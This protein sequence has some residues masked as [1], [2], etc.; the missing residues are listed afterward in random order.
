MTQGRDG[1]TLAP[2][3]A[4]RLI[5]VARRLSVVAAVFTIAVLVA[6]TASTSHAAGINDTISVTNNGALFSGSLETFPAGSGA[7]GHLSPQFFVKGK[8]TLLGASGGPTLDSVGS[9]DHHIA[10]AVPLDFFGLSAAAFGA[11]VGCGPF[12]LPATGPLFGT[13]FV[14][15]FSPTATGN[16]APENAICSPDFAIGADGAGLAPGFPNTTGVFL[17]QGVA[18]ESP[19]DGITPPGH[20][21]LAVANLFPVVLGPDSPLAACAPVPPSTTPGTSLGTITE[22][23]TTTLAPGLNNVPPLNNSPVSALNPFPAG[24]IPPVNP[25]FGV[26]YTQNATIGGCLSLLAGPIGLAFDQFGFLFV[27]N[28]AG[29]LSPALAAAPRFLTVYAPG[30]FGDAFPKAAIGVPGTDTAG[31]FKQPISVAVMTGT[32][33]LTCDGAPGTPGCFPDDVIFVTDVADN[34]IKI[35]APFTDF[36]FSTFFFQGTLLGTIHGGATKLK[37]PEGIALSADGDTLYVANNAVDSVSEFTDITSDETGG[38]IAPTLI[39]QSRHSKLNLPVGVALAG[40]TPTPTPAPSISV[41]GA[42]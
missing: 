36:S 10:V 15:I 2:R 33:P 18:Y 13:G 35:Y 29:R 12:G 19:F 31:A 3:G 41:L 23:D 28:N 37:A 11:P 6:G 9:L 8:N 25:P 40:F 20:Q 22:Y 16:S 42:E 4:R 17:P 1:T 24:G 5:G 30:A 32:I 7:H 34:S 14:E 39:I 27:V 26:F 38:N 21:I